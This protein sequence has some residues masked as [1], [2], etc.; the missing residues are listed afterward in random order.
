MVTNT[1]KIYASCEATS[2]MIPFFRLTLKIKS[3]HLGK[4]KILGTVRV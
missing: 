3:D 4:R 1:L 2:S